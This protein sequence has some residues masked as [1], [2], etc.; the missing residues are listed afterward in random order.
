MEETTEMTWEKVRA[1]AKELHEKGQILKLL[2][3]GGNDSGWVHFQI[4]DEEAETPETEFLVNKCY[5]LLD[6]GSWAGEFNASGEAVYDPKQEAFVGTDD[7]STDESYYLP[8]EE[9]PIIR[10]PARIN[11]SAIEIE[12][13]RESE[14]VV[15][16]HQ[17][18]GFKT[19]EYAE[20]E[21]AIGQYVDK[22]GEKIVTEYQ[23][24]QT[25][26]EYDH[27]YN[28]VTLRREEFTLSEDG[29]EYVARWNHFSIQ[30]SE[31]DVKSIC[32]S[33]NQEEEEDEDE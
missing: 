32:L 14:A 11:F 28:S 18:H 4:D 27:S 2:W 16:I 29:S 20:V 3:D 21:K 31:V 25:G 22:H 13:D 30:K 23:E 1:W 17:R 10:V 7:Y 15:F 5:D 8:E 6:Y 19:A 26:D 9:Q 12:S 24:A 33:L